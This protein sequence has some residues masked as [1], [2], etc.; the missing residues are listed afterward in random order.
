MLEGQVKFLETS[1][2]DNKTETEDAAKIGNR[3]H[4]GSEKN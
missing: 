1:L 3:Q 2:K 4:K